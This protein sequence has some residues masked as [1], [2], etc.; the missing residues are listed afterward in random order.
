MK[1]LFQ[2]KTIEKRICSGCGRRTT[3]KVEN[4]MLGLNIPPLN[5]TNL[6]ECLQ[7]YCNNET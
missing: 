4:L 5:H 6:F 7:K 2:I 3:T 1:S